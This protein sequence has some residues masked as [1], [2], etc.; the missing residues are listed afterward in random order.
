MS[1]AVRGAVAFSA[2]AIVGVTAGAGMVQR[3]QT[4][5]TYT[6]RATGVSELMDDGSLRR[7]D[8]FMDGWDSPF[9]VDRAT[10]LVAGGP[11]TNATYP[12]TEVV[13]TP[14]DNLFY[15]IS[16]S[17]GPNRSVN[18]LSVRESAPGSRKPFMF[19]DS[20]WVF[21]GVCESGG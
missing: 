8:R 15:I 5:A 6:C 2:V 14:P 7:L 19:I 9:N 18:L 10:G 21:S 20:A 1:S 17:A 16:K 4:E 12:I 3:P 11:A 13:F